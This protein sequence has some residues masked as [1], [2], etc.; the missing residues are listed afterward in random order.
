MDPLIS[1]LSCVPFGEL[2][3]CTCYSI[4]YQ[5]DMKTS[6]PYDEAYFQK[7]VGYENTDIANKIN[8]FRTGITKKYCNT[9]LDIG[10]GSGEFIKK[11]PVKTY[12]FDIN[13]TGIAWL[14]ERDLYVD[15]YR[16]NLSDIQGYCFWDSMEHIP[17]PSTL[18]RYLPMNS[19]VFISMPIFTNLLAIRSNKHYRPNEHYYY[20]SSDGLAAFLRMAG[21]GLI[22]ISDGETQAGRQDIYTFVFRRLN[23]I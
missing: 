8:D 1:Q 17:Q 2:N 12:G 6:V 3:Y 20:F 21:F 4:A 7:Y 15:P 9:L 19:Y 22:E 16:D 14:K 13:E 18:L 5:R 10:I 23:P 11:S